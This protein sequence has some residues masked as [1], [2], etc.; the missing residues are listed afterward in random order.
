VFVSY[1]AVTHDFT[2]ASGDCPSPADATRMSL[3]VGNAPG[4]DLKLSEDK[5]KGYK[6]FANKIW[7][8]V[9]F[10]EMKGVFAEDV[11]EDLILK[12]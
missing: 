1:P 9:K 5:V 2:V 3:L 4:N 11:T 7:N 8:A 6:H 12:D 10:A